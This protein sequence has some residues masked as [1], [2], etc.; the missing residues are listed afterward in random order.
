[1]CINHSPRNIYVCTKHGM[2]GIF[3]D[4]VSTTDGIFLYNIFQM[5]LLTSYD[6]EYIGMVINILKALN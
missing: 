5:C 4:F 3:R 2:W 6:V 1:M